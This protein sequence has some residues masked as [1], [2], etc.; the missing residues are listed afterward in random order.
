MKYR[1][2]TEIVSNILAAATGGATKTKIMY[3][4]FMSYEQLKDYLSILI[5]NGLLEKDLGTLY[6]PTKKGIMFLETTK[7]LDGLFLLTPDS[8]K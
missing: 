1:S 6:K 7:Q 3:R 4:A 8:N 2:R 5:E